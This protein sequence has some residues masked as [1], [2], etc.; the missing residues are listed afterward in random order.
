MSWGWKWQSAK[1]YWIK[2][3]TEAFR[4]H[5]SMYSFT[6]DLKTDYVEW[7]VTGHS[8]QPKTTQ[9]TVKT[10]STL[11]KW[12]VQYFHKAYVSGCHIG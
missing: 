9:S 1:C 12:L 5:L 2:N 11:Y 7:L 8:V 10:L 6:T 4:N 3:Q